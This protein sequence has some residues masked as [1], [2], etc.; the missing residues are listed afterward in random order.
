MS[1]SSV[2]DG[3]ETNSIDGDGNRSATSNPPDVDRLDVDRSGSGDGDNWGDLV[4]DRLSIL[5][6]RTMEGPGVSGSNG[7]PSNAIGVSSWSIS[8]CPTA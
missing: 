4:R 5:Y 8:N 2:S 6:P 3:G 1:A 7:G